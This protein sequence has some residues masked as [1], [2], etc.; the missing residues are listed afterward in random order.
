M[1]CMALSTGQLS[2]RGTKRD[3]EIGFGSVPSAD[4]KINLARMQRHHKGFLESFP[5]YFRLKMCK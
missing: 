5:I 1:G 3:T 4:E 2:Y